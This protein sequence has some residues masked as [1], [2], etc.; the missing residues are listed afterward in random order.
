[1]VGLSEVNSRGEDDEEGESESVLASLEAKGALG[2][3]DTA[4][5]VEGVC[6][7]VCV[8]VCV[9]RYVKLFSCVS[10]LCVHTYV[11]CVSR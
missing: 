1:M 4:A 6:V 8:C 11:V 2:K 5:S 10:I 7:C 9:K 3:L